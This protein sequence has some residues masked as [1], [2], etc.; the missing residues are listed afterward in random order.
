MEI[1]HL[2]KNGKAA[3]NTGALTTG[4]NLTNLQLSDLQAWQHQAILPL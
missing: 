3:Q 2:E 4:K 1:F